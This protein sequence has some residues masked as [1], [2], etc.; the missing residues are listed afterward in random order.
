[1]N[2]FTL[3]QVSDLFALKQVSG[4]V[5]NQTG[6]W[7]CV[8]SDRSASLSTLKQVSESVYTQASQLVCLRSNKSVS[9]FA[10]KQAIRIKHKD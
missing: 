10:L 9:L 2:Q 3:K 7:I 4:S 8:H 5:H 6:Q 1:M